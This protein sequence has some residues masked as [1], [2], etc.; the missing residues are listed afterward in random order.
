MRYLHLSIFYG[1]SRRHGGVR[2][3]EQL[4]EIL[5][6][7]D[8]IEGKSLNP[9]M[10]L[11]SSLLQALKN[12][13][14]FLI[15]LVFASYLLIAKGLSIKGFFKYSLV[16]V[17]LM[18][19]IKQY[20]FDLLLLET[21]PGVSIPFMH[22]LSWR[23]ME[24][25][26][27]PHNIEFLVPSQVQDVFRGIHYAYLAELTGY[28]SA[29]QVLAISDLDAVILRCGGVKSH[30]LEY[31][32]IKADLKRF[33][34]IRSRRL[35]SSKSG[36]FLLLGTVNNA[37][38][39]KGVEDL[40]K[41]FQSTGSK[42]PLIVAGF[43]TEMFLDYNNDTVQVLGSVTNSQL[44]SLI[45]NATALL[46]NQPQTTGFL[47]KIIEMNYC[48]LPQIILGDYMQARGMEQ[49]GIICVSTELLGELEIPS[50]FDVIPA[51]PI[52]NHLSKIF[53]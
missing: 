31:R 18:R 32:P 17:G 38:T 39:K 40:L 48:G 15:S 8:G 46:V 47:T 35:D 30:T 5:E 2:R 42:L 10:N 50:N 4:Y 22:Y 7:T 1:H 12:P 41:L 16:S 27:I 23:R 34:V 9:Y 20:R 52:D 6:S 45:S 43:G 25:V 49:Y 3:S 21:A 29:S 24:Y 51:L 11:S 37:P 36:G 19:A 13:I 33:E 53:R 26:A 28:R 44:D 14:T